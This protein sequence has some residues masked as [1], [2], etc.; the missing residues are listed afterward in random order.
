M[1]EHPTTPLRW[2]DAL[3]L[4]VRSEIKT[5]VLT[6]YQ[7]AVVL[8]RL[9][10]DDSYGGRPLKKPDRPPDKRM[11]NEGREALLKRA[12]V[13]LERTLP[14]TVLAF[15]HIR[16][17]DAQEIYCAIDPFGYVAYLSAMVYHGL[18]NRLPRVLTVLTPEPG[19]WSKLASEKLLK[20]LGPELASDFRSHG[21]PPLRHTKI[22]KL[23]GITVDV[24][25]TKELGG[26]RN[27]R[28]GAVRTSTLGRTFLQMLQRPD[29]C[30]GLNHV[31]EV[32]EEHAESH[33]VAI[34]SEFNQHGG[35]I[36]RVRAG[37]ILEERCGIRDDRIS[38]WTV[39]AA[40]GGSRKLDPQ[41]DYS[42]NFSAKWCL[43]INA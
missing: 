3:D 7:L 6:N 24:V 5:P 1:A 27:V 35:K 21:L 15:P 17:A 36:D 31:I 20:D 10:S 19:T 30:G 39:D 4:K 18:T 28:E 41:A 8:L 43:S 22:E 29:L 32:W 26:W 40:R 33:L 13:L 34:L 16:D 12:T 23:N 42:P 2:R 25:R 38:Q 11:F 14:G 9:M 37:F